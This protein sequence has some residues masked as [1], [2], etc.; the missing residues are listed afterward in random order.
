[1]RLAEQERWDLGAVVISRGETG[2]ADGRLGEAREFAERLQRS[3][4]NTAN[5]Q[6]SQC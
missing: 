1:L 5:R 6:S 2:L 3:I 4:L